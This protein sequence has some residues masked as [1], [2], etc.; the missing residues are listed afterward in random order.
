MCQPTESVPQRSYDIVRAICT[1]TPHAAERVVWTDGDDRPRMTR[2][3]SRWES[4]RLPDGRIDAKSLRRVTTRE[5]IIT[6]G[7]RWP[8]LRTLTLREA[9][10]G[11]LSA[12]IARECGF[13]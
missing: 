7:R 13:T 1:G 9:V 6:C 2:G 8:G 3:Q 4:D 5:Q 10:H 11:A 12:Q